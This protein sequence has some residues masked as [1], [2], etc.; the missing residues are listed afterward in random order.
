MTALPADQP[1]RRFLALALPLM[2]LPLL[3]P[4]SSALSSAL[5]RAAGEETGE[6]LTGADDFSRPYYLR[7][8]PSAVAWLEE[9]IQERVRPED[10][11]RVRAA[12]MTIDELYPFF[13]VVPNRIPDFAT[14]LF[15]L[16][17]GELPAHRRGLYRWQCGI[18]DERPR[19]ARPGGPPSDP[20]ALHTH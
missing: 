8:S 2:A 6:T 15:H 5:S 9:H 12:A 4:L 17:H 16:E 14:V 20:F 13:W 7:H 19:S 3:P 1:R 11:A 10:H 18:C